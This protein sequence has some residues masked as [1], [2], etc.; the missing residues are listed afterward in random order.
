MAIASSPATEAEAAPPSVLPETPQAPIGAFNVKA[1]LDELLNRH[2]AVGMAV[3]VVREGRLD[4]FY[5][6]GFADLTS[7]VPIT[8]DTVFRIASISKTFTAIAVM[9]LWEQGRIDLDTA[10]NVYLR[11]YELVPD[12]ANWRDTTVRQLLT[13]TGG[14][15]EQAHPLGIFQRDYGESVAL[16][17]RMPSLAE[18]YRGGLRVAVEPGTVFMYGDHSFATL[19]QIV[20]D[21]SGLSLAAY[22][23]AHI[24]DPLG[25]SDTDILRSEHMESRLATGYKLAARGPIRITPREWITAGA[26]NIYS[27][28]RDMSRYVA[29]LLG[30]GSNDHGTILQPATLATMLEAH[31]QPDP[32]FPGMGLGFFRADLGGHLGVEHQGIL[33]GFNSQMWVAPNDG[34]GVLAFTNG[35]SQAVMWMPPEFGRLLSELLGVAAAGVHSDMP[36]HPEVWGE[37]CGWYS[38]PI[39]ITAIRSRMIFGA[40]AEVFVRGG[41]LRC[42]FLNPIPALYKGLPLHPDNT[43][44]PYMFS[45]DFFGRVVFAREAGSGK[46]SLHLDMQPI[47]LRKQPEHTNPRRWVARGAAAIAAIALANAA[48]RR[49][50]R[51]TGKTEGA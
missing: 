9:Q 48:R 50:L 31:Y 38:I 21:V 43:D 13:H 1:W 30:G 11:A 19:G 29:A 47:S 6:Q 4:S 24:F 32:R 34:L 20:E 27:T 16:D 7:R 22:F 45:T 37:L 26:S 10:A 14:I 42:R 51:T 28:T 39:P 25:M 49:S 12:R 40:G 23:R 2:P 44:D 3:G 33:P 35:A 18:Y 15:P 36:Q 17:E 41:E 46:T 8:E 5:G